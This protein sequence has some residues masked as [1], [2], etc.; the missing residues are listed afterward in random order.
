M[1]ALRFVVALACAGCSS[2]PFTA[3]SNG[4]GAVAAGHCTDAAIV[5]RGDGMKPLPPGAAKCEVGTGFLVPEGAAAVVWQIGASP[6]AGPVVSNRVDVLVPERGVVAGESAKGMVT[7]GDAKAVATGGDAKAVATGGDAK[8]VATGGDA[9][10]VATGGD[11]KGVATGGDAKAV[12]TGGDAKGVATGGDAKAVATGGD[13]KGAAVSGGGGEARVV[14]LRKSASTARADAGEAVKFKLVAKNV[15]QATISRVVIVDRLS[16]RL[17][18]ERSDADRAIL[19]DG[20]TLLAWTV[21][22]ALA[23]GDEVEVD[24]T[25]VVR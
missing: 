25:A 5:D 14:E 3:I 19:Q 6:W 13:A 15:G 2:V 16:R 7:G 23:P 11:A 4:G 12:A 18:F 17:R 24:V 21:A 20:T 1:G 22:K 8:G 9:K 10:G